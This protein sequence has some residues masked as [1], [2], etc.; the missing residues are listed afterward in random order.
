MGAFEIPRILFSS[1][2]LIFPDDFIRFIGGEGEGVLTVLVVCSSIVGVALA[3]SNMS[4]TSLMSSSKDICFECYK[5][6][7][8]HKSF[9]NVGTIFWKHFLFY[10]N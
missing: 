2:L 9:L 3:V 5:H 1:L 8:N 7:N 4:L 10:G 6:K